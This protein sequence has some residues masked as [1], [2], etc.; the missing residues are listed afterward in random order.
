MEFQ[1]KE[2][3]LL[4]QL[5]RL[6]AEVE[7]LHQ[8]VQRQDIQL[9]AYQTKYGIV[10]VTGKEGGLTSSSSQ[11]SLTLP[12]WIA[13]PSVMPPL[14]VAYDERISELEEANAQLTNQLKSI[15]TDV[16][17]LNAANST[18]MKQLQEYAD[19]ARNDLESSSRSTTTNTKQNATLYGSSSATISGTGG[20]ADASP[21]ALLEEQVRELS[22]MNDTLYKANSLQN[23]QAEALREDIMQ[24][25][26]ALAQRDNSINE[27]S[28]TCSSLHNNLSRAN[29]RCKTAETSHSTTMS[30]LRTKTSQAASWKTKWE[31]KNQECADLTAS[32]KDAQ[33]EVEKY[34]QSLEELRKASVNEHDEIDK[35]SKTAINRA[36]DLR[37]RLNDTEREVDS[38]KDKNR[39][40]NRENE[41]MRSDCEQMLAVINKM[42]KDLENFYNRE[43]ETMI[44]A[45]EAKEKV[46]ASKLERDQVL[47][48]ETACRREI[49]R[50][51]E[52]LKQHGETA[53]R[54]QSQACNAI[55]ERLTAALNAKES[56][57][58]NLASEITELKSMCG[59]AE[60]ER[61]N[62][63]E[64]KRRLTGDVASE[65][66]RLTDLMSSYDAKTSSLE[67]RRDESL[68]SE[69]A[70]LAT[71][72]S[73]ERAWDVKRAELTFQLRETCEAL[74]N[75]VRER[76][77]ID[78]QRKRLQTELYS[79]KASLE[80]YR[81]D[82]IIAKRDHDKK[83]RAVEE[84][85]DD[86]I[87]EANERLEQTALE[88]A[89]EKQKAG[90]LIHAQTQLAH[91]AQQ[92]LE[93]SLLEFERS[94]KELKKE[95]MKLSKRNLELETMIPK[96]MEGRDQAAELVSGKRLLGLRTA[97]Q[98]AERR[99]A[100]YQ[101][102]LATALASQESQ[103]REIRIL[104]AELSQYR[105][106][107]GGKKEEKGS[108]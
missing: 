60:R 42:E 76:E 49:A 19:S 84:R 27:L 105:G 44:L 89:K 75:E 22:E 25:E 18:L 17:Q 16:G 78:N 10:D 41:T 55:R 94:S 37:Q 20:G 21:V 102:D 81:K 39:Q 24:L 46:E 70:M 61:D 29:Q 58:K 48:R 72:T 52:K 64:Q 90:K 57:L 68:A 28:T 99:A 107:T 97:L 12:P 92:E 51:L 9:Y 98:R 101:G 79:C 45:R 77:R 5:L 30:R 104:N 31:E 2:K 3:H 38:L 93:N 63:L 87:L 1:D 6:R 86:I 32:L 14:L 54:Q 47:A 108:N 73:K 15:N 69:K 65:H 85:I 26:T 67:L 59:R 43:E 50:L 7:H 103:S 95:N 106:V 53:A 74:D 56:E 4:S 71:L 33:R 36:R 62:A 40:L 35:R 34:T 23:S 100:S 80:I 82:A 88:A 96:L 13:D 11:Q 91:K 83:V 8:L 66:Q